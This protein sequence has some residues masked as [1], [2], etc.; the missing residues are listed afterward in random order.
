MNI[1]AIIHIYKSYFSLSKQQVDYIFQPLLQLEVF[2]A[3][4]M[5]AE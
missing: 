4:A 2:L 5:W 1:I 3:N